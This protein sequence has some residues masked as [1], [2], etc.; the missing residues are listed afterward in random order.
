MYIVRYVNFIALIIVPKLD[1]KKKQK[2]L[3][4]VSIR[5]VFIQLGF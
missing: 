5:R 1:K 3:D 4:I 2:K